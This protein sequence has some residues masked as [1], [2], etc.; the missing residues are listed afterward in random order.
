MESV[1]I[2]L[3]TFVLLIYSVYK[4]YFMGYPLLLILMA[5]SILLYFKGYRIDEIAKMIYKGGKKSFIVLKIFILIGAI[6]AIWMSSGTVPGIV[7]YGIK[8]LRP[9]LFILS[10]FILSSIVS[11]LIGTSFGTVSTAGIALIVMAKSGGVNISMAAGAIIAGAYFG[12]RCSPMSSSANLVASLTETDL[13]E[14]IKNMIKTGIIP[15]GLSIIIYLV[16][17]I[18]NPLSFSGTSMDIEISRVFIINPLVLLPAFI[19]LL[20][21][22]F[23]VDVKISMLISIASALLI[24]IFVQGEGLKSAVKYLIMGYDMKEESVLR[25]IIRGGGVLSMMK[26]AAIVFISSSLAGIFEGTGLLGRLQSFIE[27]DGSRA[28]VFGK[29]ILTSVFT[30]AFGCTQAISIILTNQ[31]VK[32]S[33]DCKKIPRTDLAVD[34][35]NTSVLLSP[36]IPWNIAGLVPAVALGVSWKFIPYAFYLYLVPIILYF[37]YRKKRKET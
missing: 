30:A 35:E 32:R 36:L 4:N 2:T 15:F 6:T 29:T 23:R 7:Y 20:L 18:K 19:I 31:L 12:D 34:L 1:I 28:K 8:F 37:Y 24:S 27:N 13:Y 17:S 16:L 21:S 10:A 3:G 5:Y 9:E 22:A 11:V 14:N 25:A 26:T 33:Y